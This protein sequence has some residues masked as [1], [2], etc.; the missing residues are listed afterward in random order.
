MA[1]ATRIVSARDSRELPTTRNARADSLRC[2][3]QWQSLNPPLSWPRQNR[4]SVMQPLTIVW[5]V[6][7]LNPTPDT[8]RKRRGTY[9]CTD[10]SSG[11]CN[12]AV[13]TLDFDA[14]DSSD[15]SNGYDDETV[16]RLKTA[17]HE[18]G[19]SIGL[20]HDPINCKR[21][22]MM[23]GPVPDARS[24]WVT[25]DDHDLAH[26]NSAYRSFPHLPSSSSFPDPRPCPAAPTPDTTTVPPTMSRRPG[27]PPPTT[28]APPPPTTV[29]PPPD[30]GNK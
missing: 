14:L 9:K 11:V 19:H 8:K 28:V 12:A 13:I 3:A 1:H 26:V 20:G 27:P 10:K 16:D 24:Q 15:H 22:V 4:Q 23:Q 17:F 18:V 25:F 7:D 30:P 29:A 6:A 21:S 5:K 2:E